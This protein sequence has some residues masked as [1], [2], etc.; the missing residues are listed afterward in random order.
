MIRLRYTAITKSEHSRRMGE[1]NSWI[2]GYI[3]AKDD[4]ERYGEFLDE[5]METACD[6]VFRVWG[7]T[8]AQIYKYHVRSIA[9]R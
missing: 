3:A 1:M 5:A 9:Y 7:I 2:M 6:K 8:E 4:D